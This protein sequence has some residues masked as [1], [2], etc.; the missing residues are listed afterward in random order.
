[1]LIIRHFEE[2]A[3]DYDRNKSAN[4]SMNPV[5][6]VSACR[7]QVSSLVVFNKEVN[8]ITFYFF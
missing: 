7:L 5:F 1:M 3:T 8:T 4:K 2:N 6:T